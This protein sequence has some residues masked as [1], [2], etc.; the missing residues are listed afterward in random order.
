[1]PT[2]T[3]E[4][5]PIVS[6]NQPEV[7]SVLTLLN[8]NPADHESFDPA[9]YRIETRE[10]GGQEVQMLIRDEP[11]Q[12]GE[13][14]DAMQVT[15]SGVEQWVRGIYYPV[16]GYGGMAIDV[17]VH[18]LQEQRAYFST[19]EGAQAVYGELLT[20][21]AHQKGMSAEGLQNY[22]ETNDKKIEIVLPEFANPD[23]HSKNRSP[24]YLQASEPVT[25][26]LSKPVVYATRSGSYINQEV[27]PGVTVP[28]GIRWVVG[29]SDAGIAVF[30]ANEQLFVVYESDGNMTSDR[31][32]SIA[33]S[34]LKNGRLRLKPELG[35]NR[36]ISQT[37]SG[38]L[39]SLYYPN[40]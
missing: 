39:L 1:L 14:I 6:V 3:L 31:A 19:P 34:Y 7:A 37:N 21:I 2:E 15:I 9:N 18:P 26:D 22:L 40:Q 35:A 11:T 24:S 32:G 5:P 29:Q 38:Q 13:R 36:W 33:R 16:E 20:A 23:N 4:P 28:D 27:A 17:I 8:F 10:W 12:E 25:V 30:V